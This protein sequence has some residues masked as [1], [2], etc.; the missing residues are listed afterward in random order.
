[1]TSLI[2]TSPIALTVA[3]RMQPFAAVCIVAG[4]AVVFLAIISVVTHI[5]GF[6]PVRPAIQLLLFV[7]SGAMLGISTWNLAWMLHAWRSPETAKSLGFPPPEA[8]GELS[9]SLIIPARHEQQVL[10]GTLSRIL[11]ADH[12]RYEVIVVVGDDDPETTS[13][14]ESVQIRHPFQVH[15]VIDR[16][17]SKNKAKAL[18]TALPHCHGDIVG[19]F[20]AEDDVNA[21][22][23]RHIEGCFRQGGAD[24]VQGG[25]QLMNY[26]STWFATRNVLEY[27]FW[28]KSRLHLQA[29]RG[30]FPLGGNTVFIRRALLEAAGGWDPDCLAEDCELGVRL[31]IKGAR[32]VIGYEPDLATREETPATV[33]ELFR[34]RTRWN[35]GFLQVL[36][37]RDWQRLASRKDRWFARA[38][39]SLPFAQAFL[40]LVLPLSLLT[41]VLI[42]VPVPLALF[43]IAPALVTMTTVGVEAAGLDDF[44]RSYN[45]PLSWR[46]LLRLVLGTLPYQVILGGAAI[47]A[48]LREYHHQN[49]WE[50]TTH[51][52]QHRPRVPE[53]NGNGHHDPEELVRV[54]AGTVEGPGK[55][56]AYDQGHTRQGHTPELALDLSDLPSL[57][58][59]ALG[60]HGTGSFNRSGSRAAGRT[61][62]RPLRWVAAQWKILLAAGLLVGLLRLV[63]SRETNLASGKRTPRLMAGFGAPWQAVVV[64]ASLIGLVRIA[65][66]QAPTEV[67]RART[68]E[69]EGERTESEASSDA[70]EPARAG[71]SSQATAWLAA[72]WK[73]LLAVGLFIGLIG[74]VHARGM[75]RAPGFDDDEGTYVAEA[76]A[77][78][79][80]HRL[81]PYTYWYD[82]PPLGWMLLAFWNILTHGLAWSS[83]A[84]AAGRSMVLAT[85]I[86]SSALLYGLGRRLGISKVASAA[87]MLAFGLSPLAVHLQRMVYLDNIAIPFLLAALFLILSPRRRLGAFALAGIFFACAVLIKET[88]LVLMPAVIWQLWRRRDPISWR[89]T[90]AVFFGGFLG[91]LLLYPILAILKGELIPGA[92]HVSLIGSIEW[93][94]FQRLPSGSVFDPTSGA[95]HTV[96]WWLS[97][98]LWLPVIG[99][100]ASLVG[101][102]VARLRPICFAFLLQAAMLLRNGYL[103]VPYAIAMLPFAALA[104]CGVVDL[105]YRAAL[106]AV[107]RWRS[108]S[109]ASR[110][111]RGAAS[112]TILTAILIGCAVLAH[113]WIPA[114]TQLMREADTSNFLNARHWIE[115]HVPRNDVILVDDTYWVDLVRDGFSST[116]TIWFYKFDLDPAIVRQFPA[117]WPD[118]N[119]VVSTGVM[120]TQLPNLARV[121]ETIDHS[122]VVARFTVGSD[123][124]IIRRVVVPSSQPVGGGLMTPHYR[125]R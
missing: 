123:P 28:Y 124:V 7:G 30:F 62:L 81:A 73:T 93:Q 85:Q 82:H 111:L 70:A 94:L 105:P 118:V 78:Q 87:G 45:Q 61:P 98:D 76:F 107:R 116:K 67:A 12:E 18:N 11:E 95:R 34:Q 113:T 41:T 37:K 20:D 96:D 53:G 36:R 52:G 2:A 65:P 56:G 69:D 38:T 122:V 39:L 64:L 10:D 43:A 51:S 33:K 125:L 108:R 89:F 121:K 60:G 46:D 66:P 47:R 5:T 54:P 44:C 63:A 27:F 71:R 6:D 84:V 68:E 90:T 14:A 21:S 26:R 83:S 97:M 88:T 15:V 42:K 58:S 75:T 19:V 112:G 110:A 50:K 109:W 106:R 102:A 13:I 25:V 77:V 48:L 99:V 115:S 23:L 9:F 91:V 57:N 16:N 8:R 32:V 100:S 92:G 49:G 80:W 31:S 35:Q 4:S 104:A 120:R 103:P 17:L 119:Y 1:M 101:L 72:H 114:D 55:P 59:P 74:I 3:A 79:A 117:G 24:I 22:L 29:E 86:V 40:G